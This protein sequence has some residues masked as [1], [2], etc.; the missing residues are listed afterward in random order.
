VPGKPLPKTGSRCAQLLDLHWNDS[1]L[2]KQPH[3][4]L[5]RLGGA[6]DRSLELQKANYQALAL[7]NHLRRVLV[8]DD[9]VTRGETLSAIAKAIKTTAPAIRVYGIALGKSERQSYAAGFGYM[10]SNDH[11]PLRWADRWDKP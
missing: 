1:L 4:S 8:L 11:V 9:V 6:A 5:H 3:R 2:T 7:P 10:I